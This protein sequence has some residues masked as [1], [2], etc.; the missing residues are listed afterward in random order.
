MEDQILSSGQHCGNRLSLRTFHFGQ[1]AGV[2][3]VLDS[4]GG[5]EPCAVHQQETKY[6]SINKERL[7]NTWEY[8]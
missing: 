4:R 3:F 8:L 5:E 1:R 2:H 6:N 7:G